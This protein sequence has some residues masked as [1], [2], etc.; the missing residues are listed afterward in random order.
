MAFLLRIQRNSTVWYCYLLQW[1]KIC[2]NSVCI[3]LTCILRSNNY[4]SSLIA[5]CLQELFQCET[6]CKKRNKNTVGLP[7]KFK[8]VFYYN[9]IS[10]FDEKCLKF[11]SF[12]ALCKAI[13]DYKTFWLNFCTSLIAMVSSALCHLFKAY[14]F[15]IFSTNS[16]CIYKSY[17]W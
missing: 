9:S 7:T 3:F 12:E 1:T 4:F 10:A 17:Y 11:S 5:V 16:D 15:V 13:M 8:E 14:V 2:I 6:E